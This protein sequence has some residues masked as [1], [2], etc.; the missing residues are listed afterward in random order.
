MADCKT[1]DET[2]SECISGQSKCEQTTQGKL[3]LKFIHVEHIYPER[4]TLNINTRKDP[5]L[6][7]KTIIF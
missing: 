6:V 1:V 5:G 3:Q 2:C 7:H 4:M